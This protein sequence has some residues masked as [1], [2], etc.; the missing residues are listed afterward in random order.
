MKKGKFYSE[1]N[2]QWMTGPL[3]ACYI[4]ISCTKHDPWMCTLLFTGVL[5]ICVIEPVNKFSQ[6]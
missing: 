5:T 3:T 1:W 2:V 4:N 6:L